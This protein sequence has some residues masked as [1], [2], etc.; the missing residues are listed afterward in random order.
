MEATRPVR[1][2]PGPTSRNILEP[3][4][5]IFSIIAVNSTGEA[6]WEESISRALSGESG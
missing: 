6:S 1:R 2:G 4:V 3:E 5:Y